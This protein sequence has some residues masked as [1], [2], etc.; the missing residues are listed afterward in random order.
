M[1]HEVLYV[2]NSAICQWSSSCTLFVFAQREMCV[3][4]RFIEET[5]MFRQLSTLNSVFVPSGNCWQS[6][7]HQES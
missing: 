6:E 3:L 1:F 7:K 5:E 4:Q 2:L